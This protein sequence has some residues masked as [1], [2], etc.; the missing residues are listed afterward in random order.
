MYFNGDTLHFTLSELLGVC[1][2]VSLFDKKLAYRIKCI[3]HYHKDILHELSSQPL[4]L[5]SSEIERYHLEKHVI[6]KYIQPEFIFSDDEE[7]F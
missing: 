1:S 5:T 7:I 6:Q 2:V 4:Q 3:Y